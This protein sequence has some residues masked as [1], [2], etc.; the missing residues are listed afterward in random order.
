M[1][2][3]NGFTI[4]FGEVRALERV[5]AQVKAGNVL[6]VGEHRHQRV[7]LIGQPEIG[8]RNL[9]EW[10][11][12]CFVLSGGGGGETRRLVWRRRSRGYQD[13]RFESP[14]EAA[15]PRYTYQHF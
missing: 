7:E 10:G 2:A 4:D 8:E 13:F 6:H 14:V 3:T 11:G 12:E 1:L 5:D 15:K 9:V